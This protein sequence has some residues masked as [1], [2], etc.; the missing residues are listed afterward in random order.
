[1]VG[2]SRAFIIRSKETIICLLQGTRCTSD[3]E[4]ITLVDSLLSSMTSITR[5]SLVMEETDQ[6]IFATIIEKL[7]AA[8][9]YHSLFYQYFMFKTF[10][11]I[12]YL[13]RM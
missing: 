6:S 10:K 7:V 2:D 13:Q 4:V 9:E 12:K 8:G 3:E 1:M 5:L 11:L